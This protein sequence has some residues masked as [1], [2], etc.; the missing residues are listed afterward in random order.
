MCHLKK[1]GNT[2]YL[3][4]I[5]ISLYH[6]SNCDTRNLFFSHFLHKNIHLKTVIGL[7]FMLIF[8]VIMLK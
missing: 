2:E 5:P 7:I 8:I 6:Y 4:K 3:H 1:Q